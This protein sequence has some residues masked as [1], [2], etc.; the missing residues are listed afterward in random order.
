ML[1]RETRINKPADSC[2]LGVMSKNDS[3][4]DIMILDAY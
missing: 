4:I 1:C 3:E 2:I